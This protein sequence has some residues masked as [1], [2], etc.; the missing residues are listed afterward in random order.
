[1]KKHTIAL[2]CLS[3]CAP[4]VMSQEE[5]TPAPAPEPAAAAPADQVS[6]EEMKEIVSYYL[7]FQTG[8]QFASE[9]AIE[10]DDFDREVFMRAFTDG[11]SN[12]V[13]PEMRNK[14]VGAALTAFSNVIA[15]RSEAVAKKNLE[16]SQTFFAENGKKEGIVTTES[17]LQ[18]KVLTPADGRKYDAE[19]DGPSAE[20][21]FEY[22]GRRLDGTVFDSTSPGQPASLPIN[23]MIPG[24][25]EALKSMPIGAEWEIYI[26]AEL[27]YGAEQAPPVLGPNAALIFKV[28]LVDIKPKKGSEGNPIELTPE[29]L[30]QLQEAGMQPVEQ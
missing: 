8:A 14:N 3:L 5:A 4:A 20:V 19:K 13:N 28:K 10:P 9:G 7:G 1:M 16:A 6:P 29:L 25:T 17:G 26:P 11:L 27:A 12:Q 2:L 23:G 18:Y 21:T 24:M 15:A 30:K 22:E